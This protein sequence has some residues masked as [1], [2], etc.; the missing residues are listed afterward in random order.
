MSKKCQPLGKGAI[1]PGGCRVFDREKNRIFI[2]L[3]WF[4]L[5]FISFYLRP[6][7]VS[8][9]IYS[10]APDAPMPDFAAAL[11]QQLSHFYPPQGAL[12]FFPPDAEQYLRSAAQVLYLSGNGFD[13]GQAVMQKI[14]VG[15][16]GE[17]LNLLLQCYAE[18]KTAEQ[19][20]VSALPLSVEKPLP[21]LNLAPLQKHY[22]GESLARK[23]FPLDWSEKSL[24]MHQADPLD[25]LAASSGC[26]GLRGIDS[27]D[28]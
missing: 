14:F 4:S 25:Q 26:T 16:A 18:Y 1:K 15:R 24:A 21:H 19:A 20:F 10:A 5:F 9:P 17:Y 2:V 3:F 6:A 22:F 27:N 28:S 23:L 7:Q 13:E 8:N 11:E 12:P